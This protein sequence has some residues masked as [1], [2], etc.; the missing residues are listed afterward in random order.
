MTWLLK[1]SDFHK[2]HIEMN[3]NRFLIG[4]GYMG[5]RGTLEEYT[6]EHLTACNLAGVFDKVGDCWREPVNAPNAFYLTVSHNNVKLDVFSE[7]LLEHEQC[8]DI[9]Y[10]LHS[11]NSTF[12]LK[13][14]NKVTI[15]CERFLSID[16]IHL[17]CAKITISCSQDCTLELNTGI[18]G[19]VWDLN[20]PHLKQPE[21]S[22]KDHCLI[23]T[24]L[25]SECGHRIAVSESILAPVECSDI[26]TSEYTIFRKYVLNAKAGI[27]YTFVKYIAVVTSLDSPQD[28]V[29][30]S[31]EMVKQSYEKGYNSL[32]TAH[33]ALWN[34]RW[35]DS[36]V[37]I[38]GDEDAQ[39][40][41]RY[42]IY[43]L[44]AIAPSHSDKIS[45]P[46]RGL[47]GQVYKGAAFWDTEIFMN[48]FFNLTQPM[49]AR[50]LVRY[51]INT[52]DGARRK[53]R[54]YGYRGAFYAWE[55]QET[56]DD[57]CTDYAFTDV[58]SGRP[59]RTYFRDKQI[60]ISADVAYAIWQYYLS[61][62]DESILLEGGAETI[63]ECARFF[64]SY[65]YYSKE[66]NRYEMLDVV[67][68]DEYHDRVNNNAFTNRMVK[69][70]LETAIKVI[71]LLKNKYPEHYVKLFDKINYYH[72]YNNINEMK[73][74]LYVPEPST[75]QNLIAQFD[76][77]FKLKDETLSELKSKI[78][79]SNEYL[80]G[81][82]GLATHTQIIKQADVIMMLN[83]FKSS[84]PTDIKKANWE[85]YEPRTEHGSSLSSCVY[86]L[87]AADT[88]NP[89]WA[90]KYF[91]KS[92]SI[93]LTG[94]SKQYV[95]GLYIGGTHPAANSGAWMAVVLGF[96][97]ITI[98]G[99][100][101]TIN[102]ALPR[103]WDFLA[104]NIIWK[105][106]KFKIEMDKSVIKILAGSGNQQEC[107]FKCGDSITSCKPGME[108]LLKY[109]SSNS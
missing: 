28:P 77:Y 107:V 44:L 4:N 32:L 79:I 84:Y 104:F 75:S 87:V 34:Q 82:S 30:V 37:I 56:G 66:R 85:Y 62:G 86:A 12:Q 92:A 51:R 65:S 22:I 50:N 67:G 36:D 63:L 42:S 6:K 54:E 16:N 57:A 7:Q 23:M 98:T 48:P 72:D 10:A 41:L 64:F 60:H 49:I 8:L 95:G 94:G 2:S 59:M 52:L 71:D 31:L 47:S 38:N 76:G 40:A 89:D 53:A 29:E 109:G 20:G 101:I 5:Y 100:A 90:Y 108:V 1:E 91:M 13:D 25:T 81:C 106:Q 19:D 18:D 9:S 70:T 93:D 17:G 21:K 15:K 83:L 74:L 103:H 80:G 3:G 27:D 78:K 24:G 68:P 35:A 88:G 61:T 58:F 102:P 99:E 33:K 105:K 43:H 69:L 39:F 11:R 96:G 73:K 97:G 55:S 45:I 26:V 46:A 14:G